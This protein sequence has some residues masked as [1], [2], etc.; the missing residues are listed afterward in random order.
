MKTKLISI[1]NNRKLSRSIAVFNLPSHKT[2]PGKTSLCDKSCYAKKAERL[3][4]NARDMR[5]R[6]YTATQKSGFAD[7][8]IKE[9][10]ESGVKLF[11]WHESGDWFNQRYLNNSIKIAK[12]LPNVGFLAYTRSH[13]LDFSKCPKN[14]VIYFSYDKESS[15]V[16][17]LDGY[18][19]AFMQDKMDIT[20][21]DGHICQSDNFKGLHHYCGDKCK[22][23]WN[24][25]GNVIFPIH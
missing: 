23:C 3:Y 9:I 7:E 17:I 22:Y 8:M 5:E 16:E 10:R 2:C 1:G 18:L 24:G 4:S 21:V 6:N 12:A 25:S 20:P 19:Y 15:A 11:R 14:L 13:H